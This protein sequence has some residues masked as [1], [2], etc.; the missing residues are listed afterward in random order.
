MEYEFEIERQRE[1]LEEVREVHEGE[2]RLLKAQESTREIVRAPEQETS[3]A[4]A[5]REEARLLSPR[6]WRPEVEAEARLLRAQKP[7]GATMERSR[8]TRPSPPEQQEVQRDTETI[9]E[10]QAGGAEQL[11]KRYLRDLQRDRNESPLVNEMVDKLRKG[12]VIDLSQPRAW[13]QFG[14]RAIAED[15]EQAYPGAKTE[16]WIEKG[17]PHPG[18]RGRFDMVYQDKVYEWKFVNFDAPSYASSKDLDRKLDE[19]ADQVQSYVN[20][21]D[22]PE[23]KAGVVFFEFPPSDPERQKYI[24][25]YLA[26]RGILTMW[27]RRY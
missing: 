2:E 22:L 6:G 26:K 5:L 8:E 27:G 25:Q 24:E 19:I 3:D 13:G 9:T 16:G 14:H 4:A 12:E 1:A 7:S 11:R 17:Q 21:P 10:K 18:E 23:V 15:I 20:S